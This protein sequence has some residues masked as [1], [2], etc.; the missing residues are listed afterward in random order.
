MRFKADEIV[1]VLQTEISQYRAQ[2]EAKE[3][4]RVLEVGDGIARV[5][6]LAGVMAGE[7][8]DFPRT[9][10]KGL[11]FNLEENSVGIIIL[12]EYLR[13][14]EGDEVR[15]T[16]QLLRVPVGDAIIG[17]VIDPLGNPLDGKGPVLTDL[18]RPVETVAPGVAERQPVNQ[19][20]QTGIKAIDAMT[21][22]G[23][24]QRE[25]IIGDRK[26][27]KTAIAVDTIINQKE[28]N[29][30]CV[31]VAIG[32]KES[33]VAQVVEALRRHGAMDYTVVVVA[34][35]SDPA[36]L[37]YIAP[38]AGCAMAEYY[39]YEQGRDT[40]CVYD[41]LTKQAAAYRQLSL[42]MR[43][44]PGREAYPGDIFYAHSRLLERSAKLAERWVIVPNDADESKVTAD[45]SVLRKPDGSPLVFVGPLEKAHAQKELAN[46]PGHK[47]AKVVGSGGSLTALP[48][49]ETL[50]GEVSAYIPTNVISITDGQIYLQPDLFF[51]GV[52]P[53]IDV[54]I[55]VSRVGGKAQIPAMKQVAGSL[56]LDLA[57]FRE[58]EA[59]AQLGT[60]LDKAT[61]AQLDRGYRMVEILKQPQ[62][63]P[64]HVVDQIMSIYAGTKGHLDKVPVREVSAWEEQFL[65]FMREQKPEVRTA[66]MKERRLTPEIEQQLTRSIEEFQLQYRPPAGAR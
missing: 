13:I 18:T 55:S 49:I 66:L 19:P 40:L 41:D 5:Y 46:H 32:Q 8:V 62:F 28:E 31:Y 42:L 35:S 14:R 64:M 27:G 15:T 26:T 3:V 44:P 58:L 37:Q 48:I 25:L 10:I 34:S 29:V 45:W 30:I 52:R 36:P 63:R 39:M 1:S 22:I 65:R 57:A 12:G 33:T 20:L 21:P 43:R 61:Q 16:G 59:F 17:R 56:R 50:E 6:G 7:M 53:A 47:L 4:G 23:R 2:L 24:G 54:G 11:A 9:G 38:Y 51:A 60:E